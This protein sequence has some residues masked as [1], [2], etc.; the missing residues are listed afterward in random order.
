MVVVGVERVP[1]AGMPVNVDVN[2]AATYRC[3]VKSV[4]SKI[5]ECVYW[6]PRR[7]I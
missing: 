4:F 2:H 6:P 1:L 3:S 5:L 7:R